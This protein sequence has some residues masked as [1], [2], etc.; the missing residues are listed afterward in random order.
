MPVS[1]VSIAIEGIS[2]LSTLMHNYVCDTHA[3]SSIDLPSSKCMRSYDFGVR[4]KYAEVSAME[5]LHDY[6]LL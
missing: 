4:F 3:F 5:G 2:D 1:C 6:M